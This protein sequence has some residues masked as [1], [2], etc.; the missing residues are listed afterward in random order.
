MSTTLT[1]EETEYSPL[2]AD[3]SFEDFSDSLRRIKDQ[4]EAGFGDLTQ[5][6]YETLKER[7]LVEWANW[8]DVDNMACKLICDHLAARFDVVQAHLGSYVLSVG[9]VSMPVFGCRSQFTEEGTFGE[10]IN[11]HCDTPSEE[12]KSYSEAPEWV[13]VPKSMATYVSCRR[14]NDDSRK[15]KMFVSPKPIIPTVALELLKRVPVYEGSSVSMNSHSQKTMLLFKPDW[16]VKVLRPV[17]PA[18]LVFQRFTVWERR[19]DRNYEDIYEV[20]KTLAFKIADWG[21]DNFEALK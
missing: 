15:H 18:I 6:F 5:P 11:L 7:G 4:E 14:D 9:S 20:E 19:K 2:V 21:E 10:R 3:Y 12:W 17:D 1:F 8:R 13:A 16:D